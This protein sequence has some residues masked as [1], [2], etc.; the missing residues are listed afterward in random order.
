MTAPD[1]HRALVCSALLGALLGCGSA[2]NARARQPEAADSRQTPRP[3]GKAGRAGTNAVRAGGAVFTLELE[4]EEPPIEVERLADWTERSA[5][6]IADYY[7]GTFPVPDLEITIVPGR[8][9]GVGFGQHWD[10]RWLRVWVGR[11][12]RD[13]ELHDDWVLVHEML[14]ACFP[15]LDDDRRWMQEG[16]STYL[17]PIVRARSGNMTEQDVWEKWTDSMHY[18]RPRAGDRGLDRTHTWGRTYWGGALF[19]L[20]V[21][22][23]LRRRTKG[24]VTLQTALRGFVARGGTGRVD[25]SAAKVIK[26]G[27]RV[28]RTKV[29]S[30]L[31]AKM[32]LAPG[33]VDLDALWKE[34]GVVAQTDGSVTFDDTAPLASIRQGTTRD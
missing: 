21:D 33:D 3:R 26:V 30:D 19:W 22:V 18:G 27:D 31:Y 13:E 6:M 10:G 11:G 28:T 34:L 29:F 4:G 9:R 1:L 7:G 25:W 14:H 17:E 2:S 12:T 8:Q 5:Q 24:R 15:D 16:L 23:E 32:A 20:M